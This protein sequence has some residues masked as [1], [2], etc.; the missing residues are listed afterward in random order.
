MD[1][2]SLVTLEINGIAASG[3]SHLSMDLF[4][5][6]SRASALVRDVVSQK[7]VFWLSIEDLVVLVLPLLAGILATHGWMLSGEIAIGNG[8]KVH[9]PDSDE[10]ILEL[11]ILFKCLVHVLVVFLE[12]G[13]C[14]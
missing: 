13:T 11:E 8:D 14:H 1:G 9:I 12:F 10:E 2:D 5:F 4:S 3:C 7:L 6:T